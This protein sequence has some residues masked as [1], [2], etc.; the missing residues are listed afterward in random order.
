VFYVVIRK[1]VERRKASAAA[2]AVAEEAPYA[3]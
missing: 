2:R 1:L 3:P